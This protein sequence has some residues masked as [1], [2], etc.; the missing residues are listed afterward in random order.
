ME[1]EKKKQTNH[2]ELIKVIEMVCHKGTMS[3]R[4]K[5]KEIDRLII[6]HA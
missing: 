2:E 5:V 3:D 4:D 1:N 6:E